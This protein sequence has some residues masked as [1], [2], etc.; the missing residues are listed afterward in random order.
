M[1]DHSEFNC[2]VFDEMG[3]VGAYTLNKIRHFIN[4]QSNKKIIIGTADGS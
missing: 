2:I 1:Y 3:Q 4:T